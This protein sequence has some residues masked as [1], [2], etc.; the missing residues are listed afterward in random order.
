M[1]EGGGWEMWGDS[2]HQGGHSSPLEEV[3]GRRGGGWEYSRHTQQPCK[4]PAVGTSEHL[5]NRKK[6]SVTG[7]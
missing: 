7:V 4:G 6:P 5:N 2:L 3:M 1:G